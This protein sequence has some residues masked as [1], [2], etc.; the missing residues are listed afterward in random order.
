MNIAIINISI[1][2]W[3]DKPVFPVGLAYVA[4]ALH[5]AEYDFDIIDIDARRYSDAELEEVL[6]KKSY[7]VIAFGTLVSAYKNAQKVAKIARRTNPKAIIIAGNSVASSIPAH[8]LTHTEVD[9]AVKGEGDLTIINIMRKLEKNK[10]LKD[11]CDV[12]GLVYFYEGQIIDTGYEEPIKDVNDIPFPQWDLFNIDFYISKQINEVSE[13]YPMPKED[14]RAFLVNTARGCPFRCTFCYH[15]FQYCPYRYR[16]AESIISEVATLQERYRVN[17]I[18]FWD[19]LTFFSKKQAKAFV[20]EV[21]SRGVKF[22]WTATIRGNLFS[23]E[24]VDL[25]LEL[26]EAGCTGLGYSLESA[27]PGILKSMNKKMTCEQF[28]SQKRT[29]DKA[30]IRSYTSLVIG[31]PQETLETIKKT[32]DVCYEL[33]IYPSTG[34]LLPQPGTPMFEVARQMGYVDNLESFLQQMGDRQDLRF[35]LTNIPD[36]VLLSEVEKHLK[37]ISDKVGLNLSQGNLIKTFSSKLSHYEEEL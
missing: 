9:I 21:S 32:F 15:V 36:D 11:L 16:S 8:L 2:P 19:E 29:I 27:D 17:Y 22:Y 26:K 24:D 31:F 6:C 37:R 7:D 23:D 10:S 13:P 18:Q 30:G 20:R 14:M 12:K 5:R 4:S 34:F 28:K 3:M 1:R 33:N 35:N 25:L